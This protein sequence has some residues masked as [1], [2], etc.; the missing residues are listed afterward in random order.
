MEAQDAQRSIRSQAGGGDLLDGSVSA[1]SNF[2]GV[3]RQRFGVLPGVASR[4]GQVG[5]CCVAGCLDPGA[6][7][8]ERV[9]NPATTGDRVVDKVVGHFP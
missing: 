3:W 5:E 1:E 4:S 7:A 6:H 2:R 9:A 8:R